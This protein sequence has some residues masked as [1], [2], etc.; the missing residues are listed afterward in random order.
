MIGNRI[1]K[2]IKKSE[3]PATPYRSSC[4]DFVSKTCPGEGSGCALY[5]RF[6]QG[7]R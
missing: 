3:K 4:P 2:Q 6:S 1:Q 7:L 5:W